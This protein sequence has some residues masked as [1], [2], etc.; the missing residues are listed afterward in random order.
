MG[1]EDPEDGH[2]HF[3]GDCALQTRMAYEKIVRI[4]ASHGADLSNIAR[5][6]TY[7]ANMADKKLYEAEQMCALSGIEPPPHSLIDVSSLAWPE[8]VVE[9]EVTAIVPK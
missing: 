1:A 8:M 6:V 2:I 9:V 3:P 7:L 5:V 4:L